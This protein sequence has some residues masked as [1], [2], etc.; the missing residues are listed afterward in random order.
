MVS[1]WVGRRKPLVLLGYGLAAVTKPLFPLASDV[2]AVLT[3]RFL[4][5]IGKGIRGA[6]RDALI[7]DVTTPEQRGAAYGLRQAMDTVGAFA[8]PLLAVMLML[9]T[10]D[11]VRLVFWI[12]V[13]PALA[14]VALIL[15]GVREPPTSPDRPSAPLRSAARNWRGCLSLTGAFLPSWPCSRWPVLAKHS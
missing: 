9:A 8:G 1:D 6:P 14:A 7:A 3:A 4:D 13:L 12:A 2:S 11:D 15:F 10:A 5:R